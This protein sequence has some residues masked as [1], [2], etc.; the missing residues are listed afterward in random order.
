MPKGVRTLEGM[1]DLHEKFRN[2]ANV[3]SNSSSIK[4]ELINLGTEAKPKYVN[5]E[6]CCSLGERNRF[7]NLFQ[8]YKDI[9]A[10]TYED[11]KDI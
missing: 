4:Y 7:I 11:P 2:Q 1:C 8:Q 10:W 5:F 9:F 3:K 6:K